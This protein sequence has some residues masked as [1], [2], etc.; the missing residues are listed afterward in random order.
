V[1]INQ[2]QNQCMSYIFLREFTLCDSD[3]K[4]EFH[5]A[6]KLNGCSLHHKSRNPRSFQIY[7]SPRLFT[8][9][10]S[11]TEIVRRNDLICRQFY[12]SVSLNTGENAIH[13][14]NGICRRLDNEF[15]VVVPTTSSYR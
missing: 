9:V 13:G 15:V 10:V 12:H 8:L 3:E 11:G 2:N 4:N 5:G 1:N 7:F 6:E 14:L